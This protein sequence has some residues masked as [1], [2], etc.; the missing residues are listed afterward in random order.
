MIDL[1]NSRFYDLLPPN[2]RTP[3]TAA[4]SFAFDRQMK[5]LL[6]ALPI[7]LVLAQTD[8]LSEIMCDQLAANYNIREYA[9]DMSLPKKRDMIRF[10]FQISAKQGTRW[11]V[12]RLIQ[13]I[14]DSGETEE[15]FEYGGKPYYFRVRSTNPLATPEDARRFRAAIGDTKNIRSW[16]EDILILRTWGDVLEPF[17]WREYQGETWESIRDARTWRGMLGKHTWSDTYGVKPWNHYAADTWGNL[18]TLSW[19]EIL[20]E[21]AWGNIYSYVWEET[22]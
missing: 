12:N 2:L 8:H 22:A 14:F 4:L 21:K 13:T 3:H 20:G 6:E 16:L 19:E 1:Y 18:Q 5:K 15:W 9:P 7:L 11:A 17:F 10:G